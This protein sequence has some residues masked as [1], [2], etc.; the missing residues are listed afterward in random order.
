MKAHLNPFAPGRVCR[1]LPF[2]PTLAGTDWS[3]LETSFS[4]NRCRAIVWG[5]HGSGKSTFLNTFRRRLEAQA[6]VTQL[7]FR[8]EEPRL[9]ASQRARLAELTGRFLLIDGE[10]HLSLR[11]RREVRGASQDAIGYL[12]ARHSPGRLP[13][14]L[15]L[16]SSPEIARILLSRIDEAACHEFESELPA[17]LRKKNGNLRDLWLTLYDVY[18]FR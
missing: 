16:R 15:H 5:R 1:Q 18:A 3:H 8:P 13:T 9:K 4:E 7:T 2:D 12:A 14:L 6:P 10:D 11:E 17:L